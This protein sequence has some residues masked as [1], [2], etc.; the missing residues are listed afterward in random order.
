MPE[1]FE[2]ETLKIISKILLD[3]VPEAE[4]SFQAA[5]IYLSALHKKILLKD[6]A[7]IDYTDDLQI[8]LFL[9]GYLSMIADKVHLEQI[10]GG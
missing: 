5:D 7:N 9:S 3:L 4:N 6:K 8:Y 2:K 10:K 1:Q